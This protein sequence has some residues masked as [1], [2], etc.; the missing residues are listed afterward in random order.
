MKAK[1]EQ[2][3]TAF[4]RLREKHLDTVS[5]RNECLKSNGALLEQ[6]TNVL[7]NKRCQDFKRQFELMKEKYLELAEDNKECEAVNEVLIKANQIHQENSAKIHETR[8]KSKENAVMIEMLK[9]DIQKNVQKYNDKV[10][11]LDEKFLKLFKTK[12]EC[13]KENAK[14]KQIKKFDKS[15]SQE[16]KKIKKE[17]DKMRDK[18]TKISAETNGN[19]MK[20]VETRKKYEKCKDSLEETIARYNE[21]T[22]QNTES[23]RNKLQIEA[24][25]EKT[26]SRIQEE[27]Q[28]FQ[29]LIKNKLDFVEESYSGKL[30]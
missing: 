16:C 17:L 2:L 25:F 3:R 24:S 15:T 7:D 12:E 18:Y 21:L 26:H 28:K 14:L 8:S 1:Y 23:K 11:E 5:E 30:T 4:S 22:K 29:K 9:N 20:W 19:R 10:R 27:S 13:M 6:I